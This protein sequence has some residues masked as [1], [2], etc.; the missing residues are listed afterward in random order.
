AAPSVPLGVAGSSCGTP[1]P[2]APVE[3]VVADLGGRGCAT[4]SWADGLL[5]VRGP[6]EPT[7]RFAVGQPGDELLVGDWTCQGGETVALYRPRTGQ[8]FLFDGWAGPSGALAPARVLRTG[9]VGGTPTVVP[10][11]GGD[12]ATV[13]VRPGQ[14]AVSTPRKAH[15]MP[16]NAPD[17]LP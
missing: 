14:G 15:E 11:R 5:T 6:G 13:S 4:L 16:R 7:L 12:C 17:R 10:G 8:V 3:K 9:V 1:P 2:P